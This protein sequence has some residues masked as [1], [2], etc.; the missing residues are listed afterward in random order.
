[1]ILLP[2]VVLISNQCW[3]AHWRFWVY[4]K[5]NDRCYK[6]KVPLKV[7]P[8]HSKKL[9]VTTVYNISGWFD[10]EALCDNTSMSPV[11]IVVVPP[12]K[13]STVS[14]WD[15]AKESYKTTDAYDTAFQTFMKYQFTLC[16]HSH[17]IL[18]KQPTL[19]HWYIWKY[20]NSCAK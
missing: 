18:N 10:L 3:E 12:T 16:K 14:E 20:L 1:M 6:N 2:I 19:S 15:V 7:K 5:S 9:T 17:M 8:A 11:L 13:L 4:L